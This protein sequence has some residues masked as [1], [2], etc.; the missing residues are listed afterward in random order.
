[1]NDV[2]GVIRAL[3]TSIKSL[4]L[5]EASFFK[6]LNKDAI[7]IKEDIKVKANVVHGFNNHR[8]AIML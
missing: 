8:F 4:D 3:I 7:I 6:L 2:K 5:R 1:M